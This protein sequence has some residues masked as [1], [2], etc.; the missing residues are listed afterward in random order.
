MKLS[1]RVQAWLILGGFFGL[2]LLLQPYQWLPTVDRPA[3]EPVPHPDFIAFYSA[4]QMIRDNPSA[5]YD[6]NR[7]ASAQATL[8]HRPVSPSGPEL[9]VEEM[10]CLSW[11]GFGQKG[12][13]AA[14]RP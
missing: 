1:V 8:T 11:T 10:L 12:G 5:L 6:E 3:G 7:Q 13:H 14:D 2:A 4:G 9:G